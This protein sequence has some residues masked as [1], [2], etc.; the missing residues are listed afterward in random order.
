MAHDIDGKINNEPVAWV[1]TVGDYD[2]F[3]TKTATPEFLL[4]DNRNET[5]FG[6]FQ[7]RFICIRTANEIQVTP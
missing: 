3:R 7:D 2:M 6:R 1:L 5:V 4:V